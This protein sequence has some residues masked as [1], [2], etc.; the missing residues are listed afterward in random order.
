MSR[1]GEVVGWAGKTLPPGALWCDG[2]AYPVSDYPQLFGVIGTTYGGD[3]TMFKVPDLRGR[4]IV[5]TNETSPDREKYKLNYS[6]GKERVKLSIYEM[7]EHSHAEN[8][9]LTSLSWRRGLWSN[10]SVKIEGRGQTEK[11]GDSRSH[12]NMPPFLALNFIIYYE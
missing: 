12:E 1:A 2:S 9:R 6:G 10:L 8:A 3:E 11:I 5:G 7:P 4:V